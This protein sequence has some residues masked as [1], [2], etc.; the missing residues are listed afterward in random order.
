MAT[1]DI[2]AG[3]AFVSGDTAPVV[4]TKLN[5][6]LVWADEQLQGIEDRL[7]QGLIEL[8]G[9]GVLR[10]LAVSPG[11]GLSVSVAPGAAFL[12]VVV[13]VA[14]TVTAAVPAGEESTVYLLQDG[15][16]VASTS[17]PP[18]EQA[19]LMLATVVTDLAGV[20]SV[21]NDPAGKPVLGLL[22]ALGAGEG[23]AAT[24]LAEGRVLFDSA[25]GHTHDGADSAG[26]AGTPENAFA[27]GDGTSGTK[28]L[29]AATG[30]AARPGW[31]FHGYVCRWV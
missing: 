19:A 14:T 17:G 4:R 3:T 30:A 24:L 9:V 11:E 15:S 2:P 8:V 16:L 22:P 1:K 12:G 27:I 25:S 13:V 21:D 5:D 28:A 31:R 26:L 10:G 6:N 29:Y 7:E 20:V 23:I 18:T